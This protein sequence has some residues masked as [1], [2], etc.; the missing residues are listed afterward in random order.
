MLSLLFF[1]DNSFSQQKFQ[2]ARVRFLGTGIGVGGQKDSSVSL[3]N[4]DLHFLDELE[5]NTTIKV[6][7]KVYEPTLEKLDEI[8]KF[9][10]LFMHAETP[11][12]FLDIEIKNMREY[13]L[14]GG[15]IFADDCVLEK[16][17]DLFFKSFKETVETRVFPDKKFKKIDI[18]DPIFHCHFDLPQGLP[19]VQGVPNGA[20]GLYD[21]K[22]RIMIFA[23]S[24]DLHCGWYKDE[25]WFEDRKRKEA[26]QM[27]INIVIYALTH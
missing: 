27:G 13:C 20:W 9:P 10:I 25:N 18:S 12:K 1:I 11:V 5:K 22:G 14:R 7:K 16:K 17:G 24:T 15:F 4:A 21:D 8:T 6:E 19:Y 3:L 2:W 26:Y 23:C